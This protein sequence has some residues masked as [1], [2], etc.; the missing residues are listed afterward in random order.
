MQTSIVY[1]DKVYFVNWGKQVNRL[2]IFTPE[3]NELHTSQ[4]NAVI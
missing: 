2:S 3:T 4:P 1:N